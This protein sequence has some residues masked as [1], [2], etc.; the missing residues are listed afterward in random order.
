MRL[1]E[2]NRKEPVHREIKKIVIDTHGGLQDISAIVIA[3][4]IA[5]RDPQAA[6][7]IGITCVAGKNTLE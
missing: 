6:K 3:H 4:K 5:L 1:R 7:I 2:F